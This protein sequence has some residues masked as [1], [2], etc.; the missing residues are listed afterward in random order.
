MEYSINHLI[1][2]CEKSFLSSEKNES[3][4]NNDILSMKGMSGIKTRHLY[5]NICSL[6]NSNY[7]EIG[8]WM[9]SSF[10]SATFNNKINAVV[11]DNWA[12]FN[13]SKE[14]FFKNVEVYCGYKPNNFIESDCFSV[15]LNIIKEKVGLIDIFMYDGN[16]SRESQKRAITYY[17][18]ILSKNSIIIIDDFSYPIVYEG[19]YDGFKESGLNVRHSII[20]E[21]YSEKG[22]DATYWN[23][24]GVFVCEK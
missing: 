12:E 1:S 22:G 10:I 24:V 18:P 2:H 20:K 3:K 19:T 13:G 7:L 23:G 15:D 5:N 16:H 11:I 14:Q 8:T 17:Y 21:C 4:L 9:G 6:E